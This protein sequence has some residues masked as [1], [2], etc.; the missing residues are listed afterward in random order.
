MYLPH[1]DPFLFTPLYWPDHDLFYVAN[2][3]FPDRFPFCVPP[4]YFIGRYQFCAAAV[5]A[6]AYFPSYLGRFLNPRILQYERQCHVTL[7]HSCI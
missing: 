1:R 6:A 5:S 3:Y 4:L 2:P 7:T